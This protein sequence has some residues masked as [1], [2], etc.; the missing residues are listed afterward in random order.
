MNDHEK[1][2]YEEMFVA[3]K[4]LR[5]ENEEL[6]REC[7]AYDRDLTAAKETIKSLR[8]HLSRATKEHGPLMSFGMYKGHPISQIPL[9]YANW[10]L[11]RLKENLSPSCTRTKRIETITLAR[12]LLKIVYPEPPAKE[13]KKLLRLTLEGEDLE[14]R[15]SLQEWLEADRE[16]YRLILWL[17]V[18]YCQKLVRW[19]VIAEK[20]KAAKHTSKKSERKGREE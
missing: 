8:E 5:E 18:G 9:H 3:V 13:A 17:G 20:K 12:E 2:R 4:H 1:A 19:E 6:H 16:R 10:L 7:N 11:P 15:R 14:V